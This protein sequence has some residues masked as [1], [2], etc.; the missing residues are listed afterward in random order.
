MKATTNDKTS[1]WKTLVIRIVASYNS[2]GKYLPN[3]YNDDKIIIKTPPIDTFYT[4]FLNLLLFALCYHQINIFFPEI[5][6]FSNKI[7]MVSFPETP[8]K[9]TPAERRI[10][11]LSKAGCTKL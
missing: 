4:C 1:T 8:T 9:L 5:N 11:Y 3:I 6:Q 10:I 7:A 2:H